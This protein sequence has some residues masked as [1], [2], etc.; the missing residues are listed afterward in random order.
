MRRTPL[1]DAGPDRFG[2]DD[3]RHPPLWERRPA[4]GFTRGPAWL[5]PG[6]A[7]GTAS[8]AAQQKDADSVLSLYRRLIAARGELAGPVTEVEADGGLLSFARGTGHRVSLNLGGE[9]RQLAAAEPLVLSAAD[10]LD[11]TG[12]LRGGAGALLRA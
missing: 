3:F 12:R 1:G 6:D 8:A 5:Q 9:P 2:R 11:A 4:G 7:L 10:A